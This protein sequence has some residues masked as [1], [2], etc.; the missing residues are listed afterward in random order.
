VSVAFIMK[1]RYIEILQC[2]SPE[3]RWHF[4]GLIKAEVDSE[5]NSVLKKVINIA[6]QP[7]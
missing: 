1:P 7:S 6:C 4:F 3:K 2:R 5:A